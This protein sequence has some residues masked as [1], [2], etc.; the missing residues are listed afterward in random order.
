MRRADPIALFGALAMVAAAALAAGS[1]VPDGQA[2][3]RRMAL[4]WDLIA[5]QESGTLDVTQLPARLFQL[6]P[7]QLRSIRSLADREAEERARVLRQLAERYAEL[8]RQ[9]LTEN[10]KRTYD[11]ALAALD[12]LR[13]AQAAAWESFAR[14]AGLPKVASPAFRQRCLTMADPAELLDLGDEVRGELRKARD[15]LNAA[16][17]GAVRERISPDSRTDPEAWQ[18]HLEAFRRAQQAARE[19]FQKRRAELLGPERVKKLEAIEAALKAY[20]RA[21]QKARRDAYRKLH[22]IL[23]PAAPA[24]PQPATSSQPV[25]SG[26]Q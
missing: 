4:T 22:E 1:Q 10:Q 23:E 15:E 24:P 20:R 13:A 6:T 2:R 9:T 26:A 7:E 3:A 12:E 8:T 5:G 16:L 21:V 14:V 19:A 18:K 17:G 25:A 11:A